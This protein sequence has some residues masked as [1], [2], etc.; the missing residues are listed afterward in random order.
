MESGQLWAVV[1]WL[2]PTDGSAKISFNLTHLHLGDGV[3]W[4]VDHNGQTLASG[5]LDSTSVVILDES[6]EIELIVD[7]QEGDRVNFI[8][9]DNT[10]YFGD[11]S[12]LTATIL[13]DPAADYLLT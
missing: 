12:I 8:V 2:A 11:S 3:K 7:V 5:M 13:F 9:E 4:Y 1:S 6:G 10:S